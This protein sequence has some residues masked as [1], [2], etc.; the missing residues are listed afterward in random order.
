MT[1]Q[2][3]L[4]LTL[5]VGVR[6]VHLSGHSEESLITRS[7]RR[8]RIRG[9][10]SRTGFEPTMVVGEVGDEPRPGELGIAL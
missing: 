3:N 4:G 9:I 8:I 5:D 6:R 1:L 10:H 7:G 2:E